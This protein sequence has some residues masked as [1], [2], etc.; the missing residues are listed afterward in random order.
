MRHPTDG[1]PY[2]P[3]TQGLKGGHRPS[4][5]RTKPSA[6]AYDHPGHVKRWET[7]GPRPPAKARVGLGAH[8]LRNAV[9]YAF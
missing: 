2:R 9:L 7:F 1:S 6:L 8:Q 5:S 4:K 3:E